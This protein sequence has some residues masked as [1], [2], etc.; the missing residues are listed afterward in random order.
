VTSKFLPTLKLS[1][2]VATPATSNVLFKSVPPVTT[3][4]SLA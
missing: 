2:M 1:L 3:K 4:L